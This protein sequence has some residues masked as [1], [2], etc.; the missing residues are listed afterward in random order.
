MFIISYINNKRVLVVAAV[1]YM[2]S[3]NAFFSFS[4]IFGNNLLHWTNSHLV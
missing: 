3:A 2:Q 1:F 4:I